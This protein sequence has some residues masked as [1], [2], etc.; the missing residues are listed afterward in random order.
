V[1]DDT[2]MTGQVTSLTLPTFIARWQKSTL[3]ERQAVQSHLNELCQVLGQAT[4]S[5]DSTGEDNCLEK[6]LAK[7]GGGEGRADVW[8]VSTPTPAPA[9]MVSGVKA[10]Q[11]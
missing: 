4:P 5:S 2:A 7:T 11:T 1:E 9:A 6:G 10:R 3:S 8:I